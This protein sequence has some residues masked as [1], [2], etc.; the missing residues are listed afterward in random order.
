MKEEERT[1][2]R[3]GKEETREEMTPKRGGGWEKEKKRGRERKQWVDKRR[4][5]NREVGERRKGEKVERKKTY[6]RK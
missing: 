2:E 4:N 1:R 3:K 5:G 6:K